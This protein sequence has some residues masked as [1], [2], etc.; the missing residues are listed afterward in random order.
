MH[1]LCVLVAAAVSTSGF[2]KDKK[3]D[4][5]GHHGGKGR[6]HQVQKS[7]HKRP[8]SS[9]RPQFASQSR[10]EM[11]KRPSQPQARKSEPKRKAPSIVQRSGGQRHD[12]RDRGPDRDDHRHYD[13]DDHR[14]RSGVILGTAPGLFFGWRPGISPPAV[15][16]YPSHGVSVAEIQRALAERGY[17]HG[18]IDGDFGP[19]TSRA[20]AAF[21]TR[22][23]LAVTGDINHSL[24]R[25]LGL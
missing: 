6:S 2:A 13:R 16:V 15:P 24:V 22:A 20:I 23:G 4:G 25:A 21:Q 5:R 9:A 8:G 19:M 12:V 3:P 18:Y 17:Y 1:A 10:P 11:N 14:R 7:D